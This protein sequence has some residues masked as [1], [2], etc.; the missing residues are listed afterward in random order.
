MDDTEFIYRTK[1]TE[2][3]KSQDDNDKSAGTNY[4]SGL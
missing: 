4:Y 1:K 3:A 2:V